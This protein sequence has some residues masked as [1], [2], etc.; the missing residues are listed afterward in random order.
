MASATQVPSI[1]LNMKNPYSAE[2]HRKCVPMWKKVYPSFKDIEHR[3]PFELAYACYLNLINF[4]KKNHPCSNCNK[5]LEGA[6]IYFPI[7][8]HHIMPLPCCEKCCTFETKKGIREVR[9]FIY[10][11]KYQRSIKFYSWKM[12]VCANLVVHMYEKMIKEEE[13]EKE[14]KEKA[15]E[16]EFRKIAEKIN[17]WSQPEKV[18]Q[19]EEVEE[20]KPISVNYEESNYYFGHIVENETDNNFYQNLY[21]TTNEIKKD[22]QNN[23]LMIYLSCITTI[24]ISCIYFIFANVNK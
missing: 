17:Q 13:K 11:N 19:I 21:L 20:V 18:T 23:I 8:D 4:I 14:E 9:N 2:T 16:E 5:P 22:N 7:E 1:K 6:G 10:V 24:L 15:K 3:P 12:M